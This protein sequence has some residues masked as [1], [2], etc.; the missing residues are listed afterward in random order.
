[1]IGAGLYIF[2]SVLTLETTNYFG[3]WGF[4]ILGIRGFVGPIVFTA[5]PSKL[6]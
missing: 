5:K 1:M 4:N 6:G 3:I 2:S